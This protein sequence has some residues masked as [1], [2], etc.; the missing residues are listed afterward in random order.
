LKERETERWRWEFLNFEKFRPLYMW[1]LNWMAKRTL[2]DVSLIDDMAVLAD[3]RLFYDLATFYWSGVQ[4]QLADLVVPDY[5][6]IS[7]VPDYNRIINMYSIVFSC[8]ISL[9]PIYVSSVS[10]PNNYLMYWIYASFLSQHI[11]SIW[12]WDPY[13]ICCGAHTLRKG[14]CIYIMHEIHFPY[15][16]PKREYVYIGC[17]QER[18]RVREKWHYN[19]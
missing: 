14:G 17:I 3:V 15:T 8:L 9:D 16:H 2:A 4:G 6:I 10:H 5:N 11:R 19:P 13:T 1:N 18:E 12:L 7:L